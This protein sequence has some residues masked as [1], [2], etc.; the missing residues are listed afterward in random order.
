MKIG[1]VAKQAGMTV[2]TIR[3]Y[4]KRGLIQPPSR[5]DSGYRI[6]SPDIIKQ[7]LFITRAKELGFSLKEIKELFLLRVDP[8]TTCAEIKKQ[9]ENKIADI[10]KKIHDLELIKEAL[11]KL[12]TTCPGAGSLSKCPIIE[13]IDRKSEENEHASF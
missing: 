3:F 12:A 9:T 6:Y 10:E 11:V 2:E 8:H 5:N 13:A 4:E 1:S 7:L